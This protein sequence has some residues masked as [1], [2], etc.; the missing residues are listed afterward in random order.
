MKAWA[1]IYLT[2]LERPPYQAI[3]LRRLGKLFLAWRSLNH[4][5][6]VV[7]HNGQPV[8]ELRQFDQLQINW[9]SVDSRTERN[10]W[11]EKTL[12]SRKAPATA[13]VNANSL[14]PLP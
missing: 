9:V 2:D 14:P 1:R 10:V 12:S 3:F 4:S 13:S 6:R 5:R 8:L 11:K 7:L